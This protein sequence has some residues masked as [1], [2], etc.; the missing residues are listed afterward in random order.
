MEIKERVGLAIYLYYNRDAR[1]L[2][3]LGDI[4]YHSK[5]F[6]YLMMYIDKEQEE[7]IVATLKT[8]KFVKKVKPSALDDIDMNFVGNLENTEQIN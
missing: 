2:S 4:L 6:K 8:M 3:K 5:R 1:K 7:D